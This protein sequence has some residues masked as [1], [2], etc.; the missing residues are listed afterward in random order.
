MC[1]FPSS[2]PSSFLQSRSPP[3]PNLL[4]G[5]AEAA[6][7]EGMYLHTAT[8]GEGEGEKGKEGGGKREEGEG[9]HGV[10]REKGGKKKKHSQW[11]LPV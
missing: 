7:G 11:R 8:D 9:K 4:H 3:P 10:A 2:I 1:Y 5:A 6:N